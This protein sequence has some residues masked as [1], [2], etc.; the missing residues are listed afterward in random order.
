MD[1]WST[2]G[3]RSFSSFSIQYIH[4][5]SEDPHVWCLKSHLIEFK[6]SVGRHTGNMIE[7]ETV[8]VIKK[9]GMEKKVC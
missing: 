1:G 5:P 2:K 4:S 9:F 8:V 7:E 6:R 3:R